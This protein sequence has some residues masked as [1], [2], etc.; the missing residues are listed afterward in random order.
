MPNKILPVPFAQSVYGNS[1]SNVYQ[2]ILYINGANPN[3]SKYFPSNLITNNCEIL[4]PVSYEI[5]SENEADKKSFLGSNLSMA[6]NLAQ[7][8]ET[9]FNFREDTLCLI[10]G[11]HSIAIGTGAGL[12]KLTNLSKIG[13]IWIDAH[14]DFNTPETSLSKS[15]TGYP[16]AINT[17]L[18]LSEFTDLYDGNFVQKVV[19]IGLRDVDELESEN[20]KKQN[21]K[22]FSCIEVEEFGLANILKETLNYLSD[23][24]Y[25]WLSID[26]DSLDPVYFTDGETDVPALA[27]LTPREL[28]FITS[29]IQETK[30]LKVFEIVQLNDVGKNTDLTIL[31]SRLIE[32]GFGLAK[33]RYAKD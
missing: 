18:G 33:H 22:T 11:D 17:G 6:R 20:L 9:E 21:V 31:A 13:L 26:F 4:S 14:G 16:C 32:L 25:L 1:S 19:Q 24:D 12:S 28:I 3:H 5:Q 8:I 10:G 29:K 15:I 7:R 2:R 27:G 23:C 30:K